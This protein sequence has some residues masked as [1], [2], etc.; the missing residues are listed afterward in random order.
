MVTD[1]YSL[2]EYVLGVSVIVW[3][4]TTLVKPKQLKAR[5]NFAL[6]S[7]VSNKMVMDFTCLIFLV[8]GVTIIIAHNDWRGGLSLITTVLG[9]FLAVQ[10]FLWLA[11]NKKVKS[12]V[13]ALKPVIMKKGFAVFSSLV[14]IG[15]GVAILWDYAV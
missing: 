1:L 11:F 7:D 13:K 2:V 9:W 12:L 4:F 8:F 5:I 10:A 3:G 6:S 15:L 14:T